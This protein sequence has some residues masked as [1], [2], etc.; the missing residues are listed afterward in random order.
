MRGGEGDCSVV[1]VGAGAAGTLTASHLVTGLSPRYRVALV[2]PVAHDRPRP[3]VLHDRRAAPA[4]RP[5]ERHERLPARPRALL[6][7][8][9]QPPRRRDAAAGLRAAARVRRLR[10][11]PAQTAA[12]YPGNARLER[13]HR[14][15]AGID[16]RGDRFVVRLS[17]AAVDRRARRRAGHRRAG[18]APTGRRRGS[19]DT[20][21]LVAD[22]WT[23]DAARRRPAARRHRPDAWSTSRSPPTAPGPD[24]AHRLAPRPGARGAPAAHHPRRAAAARHHPGRQPR[25]AARRRATPRRAHRRRDRRLARRGRRPA[26]GHRPAVAGPV[27]R[28]QAAVP[29]R[30]R[31]HLGRPPPPDAPGHRRAG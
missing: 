6:P 18:P 21:R 13:R 19:R 2:D 22:P 26:P 11:G 16:R 8:G 20:D 10:R 24:P 23:Q 17:P 14:A 9:P 15:V 30:A 12:E 5:R 29:R 25:R 4:Q 3:G 31:P 1:V 28:G 27:R 7:V